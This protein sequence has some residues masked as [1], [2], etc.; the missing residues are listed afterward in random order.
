MVLDKV[1][2]LSKVPGTSNVVDALTKSVPAPTL[3]KHRKFLLGTLTLFQAFVSSVSRGVA[4]FMSP[5]LQRGVEW[6]EASYALPVTLPGK[7]RFSQASQP[8]DTQSQ[9]RSHIQEGH[10]PPA[11][12]FGGERRPGSPDRASGA[13]HI[14]L[15]ACSGIWVAALYGDS[16]KVPLGKSTSQMGLK[17]VQEHSLPCLLDSSKQAHLTG[18][19]FPLKL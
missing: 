3:V 13:S 11:S 17:P 4:H 5:S 19:G 1:L 7:G 2:Y 14:S 10:Q 9:A 6:G 18:S 12:P 15:W 8:H 16:W